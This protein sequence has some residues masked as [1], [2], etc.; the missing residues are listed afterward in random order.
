MSVKVSADTE[1]T[2]D[3]SCKHITQFTEILCCLSDLSSSSLQV[4]L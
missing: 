4:T 1:I 3:F 2:S